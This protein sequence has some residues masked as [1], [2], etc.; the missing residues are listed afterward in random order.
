MRGVAER[1]DI[2]GDMR[3]ERP[4]GVLMRAPSIA[5]PEGR[6]ADGLQCKHSGL[7]AVR[8]PV[9]QMMSPSERNCWQWTHCQDIVPRW[10]MRDL[11]DDC[12]PDVLPDVLG[13]VRGLIVAPRMRPAV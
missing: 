9:P 10:S 5:K 8:S 3:G 6:A 2:R 4:R 1:G 7:H 12:P 13:R 11:S